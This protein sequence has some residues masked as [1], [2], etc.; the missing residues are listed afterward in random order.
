M[1]N[2]L[3]GDELTALRRKAIIFGAKDLEIS[4]KR[5]KKYMVTLKN[6]KKVHFGH[7]YFEDFLIH[8]DQ[9]RRFRY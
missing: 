5:N 4:D 3:E 8:G 1:M 2:I 6:G 7:P 9:K